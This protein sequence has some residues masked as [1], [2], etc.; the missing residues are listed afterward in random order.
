[1]PTLKTDRI[2]LCY[3]TRGHE[4]HPPLLMVMGLGGQLVRWPEKFLTEI[5]GRGFRLILFDNRDVGLSTHFH[6]AGAPDLGAALQ[7]RLAGETPDLPYG[8]DDMADDCV[9]LLDALA[10]PRAHVL[11][12]SMGGMV[13]QALAIRHPQRLHSLTSIMSSTGNPA[14]PPAKPEVMAR[15]TIPP[16]QTR[17]QAIENAVET[18]RLIGSTVFPF[19]EDVY[20]ARAGRAYDRAYDPDGV[21]RQTAA[22]LVHGDRSEGLAGLSLPALVVHGSD[23]PLVP[24]E[25][26]RD[27]ARRIPGSVLLEIEG[28]AHDLPAPVHARIADALAALR[29]RADA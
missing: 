19:E 6:D 24:I 7:A 16:A 3:E 17:E 4:D 11:G 25:G 15:L 8:L 29:D 9:D 5:E 2:E 10:L 23:D 22:I 1:M 27:T 14:L 12:V 18:D 26:G 13:A 28:M 20:R 21:A